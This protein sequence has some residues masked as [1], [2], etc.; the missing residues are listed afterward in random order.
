MTVLQDRKYLANARA[1]LRGRTGRPTTTDNAY[2][3][4]ETV[5]VLLIVI[6]PPARAIMVGLA[7]PEVAVAIAESLTL[8]SM[9][10]AL[11]VLAVAIVVLGR[12]R[13][14][15]VPPAAYI[16]LVVA[17]PLSR[18]V[19]LRRAYGRGRLAFVLLALFGAALL[20]GGALFAGPIDM[21]GA[22]LFL[23][24]AVLC[25][26][27][28]ALLWLVGQLSLPARRVT[29]AVLL[30]VLAVIVLLA[31]FPATNGIIGWLGP[32]GW[33]A[34]VWQATHEGVGLATWLALGALIFGLGATRWTARL[35]D[36]LSHE[37]LE[38]QAQR[39]GTVAA[40]VVSGDV[41]SAINKLK[42]YPKIG[43]RWQ[44]TFPQSPALAIIVRDLVGLARFP[45]RAVFW[46]IM[47]VASGALL[48]YTFIPASGGALL[49][50]AAPILMYFAVG[51]WAE[52][53]RFH[54]STVGASSP[55]GMSPA[56]QALTHLIVPTIAAEIL[57]LSGTVLVA[58][59]VPALDIGTI[60][61]WAVALVAFL[62]V[63]QSFSA[64]KGLL[65]IELL[66]PMPTP[67]G[68]LAPLNVAM[69]LAD[70]VT[71]VLVVAGVLT[72]LVIV[73]PSP[74]T[75]LVLLACA[76]ALMAWWSWGRFRRLV[77]P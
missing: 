56:R 24:S 52:G 5:L 26:W 69:W 36:S 49:A 1:V 76:G 55:S 28:I 27:Q 8:T 41:K 47:S 33:V 9:T 18:S 15:V 53:L 60:A 30:T 42:A 45:V 17:S 54:A 2:K 31:A 43:R 64:F 4:Y 58:V 77:R 57:I 35:L 48:A 70:A 29:I 65:P 46:A 50:V 10:L 38:S 68:D 34:H 73:A 74:V 67:L 44:V 63:M 66:T 37:D 71:V 12:I 61:L 3:I 25:A 59:L 16:D 19:T 51:G 6:I 39:W 20:A 21:L 75:L 40:L 13:G 32:W 72:S 11:L 7:V 23:V 14:P 62:V 22:G